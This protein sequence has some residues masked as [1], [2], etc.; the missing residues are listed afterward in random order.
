MAASIYREVTRVQEYTVYMRA[1]GT[2]I[3]NINVHPGSSQTENE[4]SY[5]F[6]SMTKMFGAEKPSRLLA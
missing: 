1:C 3:S 5:E 4:S 2:A 6:R